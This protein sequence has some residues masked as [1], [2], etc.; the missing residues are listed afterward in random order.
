[1][2]SEN[3]TAPDDQPPQRPPLVRLGD[4]RIVREVG[5]GGMGIV[6]EAEQISL[7][8]RVALKVLPQ[9]TLLE[10]R[11]KQRFEREARSAA[12]LHHTN[13]VSV[14][15]VGEEDGL[16]YIAMEFIDGL[17][18]DEVLRQVK[19][20]D[21]GGKPGAVA[22]AAVAGVALSLVTGDF[23]TPFGPSQDNLSRTEPAA[24]SSP[25]APGYLL[26]PDRVT[27]GPSAVP[28]LKG[29]LPGR[30]GP[31]GT[32]YWRSVA[33]IGAQVADALG[34]AHRQGIL[35]RDVKPSNLLLDAQ[36]TVWVT[37]FGLAKADDQEDLTQTGDIVGT[38]RY[39]PPEAFESRTD[40]RGD[41]YSLGL[42]LYEMLALRPAFAESD[43]AKLIKQV[44]TQEPPRLERLD[45][46]IPRDLAT[47]VHK[48]CARE[49]ADRYASA[50]ELAAD[51]RRFLSDEPI[52]ARRA[53][54]VEGVVRWGRRHPGLAAALATIAVL[55]TAVAVGAGV[56][57]VQLRKLAA[58][59]TEALQESQRA[60]AQADEALG[61]A[62][63][64]GDEARRR[65]DAERWQRYRSN[66]AAAA[67]S[68]QLY[69]IDSVRRALE[70]APLEHRNWE[71]QYLS[72]QLD[73]SRA[74]LECK[75]NVLWLTPLYEQTVILLVTTPGG[76]LRL[77][78]PI[79]ARDVGRVPATATA[80]NFVSLSPDGRHLAFQGQGGR[81]HLWD[82]GA[83]KRTVLRDEGPK[84][85][86]YPVFSPDG[87]HLAAVFTDGTLALWDVSTAMPVAVLTDKADVATNAD[88]GFSLDGRRLAYPAGG[89]VSVWDADSGRPVGEV[90]P[91]KAVAS[92]ALSPDGTRL[93]TGGDYPENTV[94]LWDVAGG[95]M[96]AELTGHKNRINFLSFSPDGRR[97]ASASQDQTARLWDA[98]AGKLIANLTGHTGDVLRVF[99]SP[100][101]K[102]LAS[103]SLDATVRLWDATT[104]E[105]DTVLLGHT[106][107]IA[108]AAFRPDGDLLVT[109]ST[110]GTQR[111]WDVHQAEH[112]VCRGHT[113]FVYDLAFRPDGKAL[114]SAAWDGTVRFW[115]V[116]T[117]RQTGSL[118]HGT[119]IVAALGFRPD[120]KQLASV[121]RDNAVHLWDLAAGKEVA[122]LQAPT[123]YWKADTH[124][125]FHPKKDL[126][127]AGATD[128]VV[129]L[130]STAAGEGEHRRA[131]A[132]GEHRRA[133][134]A[135]LALLG[136][137]KDDKDRQGCV[138]DV[139]FRPPD[140][141]QLAAA[142]EDGSVRLWDV[143]AR[144][145]L[146]VLRGHAE[147]TIVYR[148][149]YSGDGRLLA[150]AGEDKSV[151]LWDAATYQLLARLP[152]GSIVYA[153]AFS[154]DGTRL[155]AGCA[156]NTIRLWDVAT[157]EEVA[158][159][160]GH[161]DYVHA[162]AFSPDGTRLASASG[163]FTVR[164]WDAVPA[165]VRA[166]PADA[167]VPPRGYVCYRAAQPPPFDGRLDE[168]P[169][170]A[171]PWTEDFVDIEGP[172]RLPPR[173]RTR[174]KMLWDDKY[175]YVAAELE[176]PHVWATLTEHD[177]VIFR[178]NDFE[179]FID[180]DGD[181]HNYAEL[182]LNALNTTWDLLLTKPYRDKGD[183]VNEWEIAGLKTAVHIEGVLNNP[184]GPE[185]RG[186]TVEIAIPWE[187]LSKL[188]GQAGPPGD[189]DQWRVN[190]SRV[191]WRTDVVD[192][193]YVKV[194]HRREDNWVWSPQGVVDMHRPETWGYVQF[195]TADPGTAPFRPDPAGPAKHLLHRI[196][197]AQRAFHEEHGSYA[198]SL[199]ELGLN[200]L[201]DETLAG[202]L[203]LQADGG[204]FQ[205]TAE[206]RLPGG[207]RQRWHIRQDSRVWQ[208]GK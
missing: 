65:G 170:K 136:G 187:A 184:R 97:L 201:R 62:E 52:A 173:F 4:F 55:L 77:V 189:G 186:W 57:A 48:A 1:M 36:G 45:P 123:I 183:A 125:A 150:S 84:W 174:A 156:D 49:P 64:S 67:S 89:R 39:L 169:W 110:D 3:A 191:E 50:G 137:G 134:A 35:H 177:A 76:P 200:D 30:R 78:D 146:T 193:K 23:L 109:S 108:Q 117:G 60:R 86:R 16:P 90:G 147:N 56:T 181:N 158:E 124:V 19:K 24:A 163:D 38:L 194:P 197:Y 53:S 153:A 166:R 135:P 10:A 155:A 66:I 93:A 21:N 15:G 115:D 40:A 34:H 101:G 47:V 104:G 80:A 185:D 116:Q 98:A 12:R 149:A 159:L 61:R 33:R 14:Y 72:S 114:A 205:A 37:D 95:R 168:G 207:R 144:R 160:R 113:G 122:T 74:T 131:D 182:E 165:G 81:I 106:G 46:S 145:P 75:E 130:W 88:L 2:N 151:C 208:E 132:Q 127:A 157:H 204:G 129:R 27:P 175:F 22:D 126:I 102:H 18:L 140:G 70:A 171:A 138:T 94:R 161:K 71:W 83:G 85:S 111:L 199:A 96:T 17:G 103:A 51:L 8:R 6:Y 73:N 142:G 179:V 20:L 162:V 105:L 148:L 42:T 69:N 195:S 58:Q 141:A 206:V 198:K 139:A 79:R 32:A 120:G 68:L 11:H 29:I 13:I 176:E 178:D 180:P 41:I 128:G 25:A 190:F 82:A 43:R 59:E 202:P 119:D 133:D 5:R 172:L 9:Q 188:S 92:V 91:V 118:K 107:P 26:T 203:T 152:H 167:Y 154:P 143:A 100:D 28:T 87:R 164:L 196:Y 7:G 121:A 99:F 44:T 31:R 63:Q 54:W 112:K 192:G